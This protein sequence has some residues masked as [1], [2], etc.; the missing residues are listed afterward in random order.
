MTGLALTSWKL[1]QCLLLKL[2]VRKR[3]I[4]RRRS[5][6]AFGVRA[7]GYA[8]SVLLD[9]L[10]FLNVSRYLLIQRLKGSAAIWVRPV[11]SSHHLGLSLWSHRLGTKG[12]YLLKYLKKGCLRSSSEVEWPCFIPADDEPFQNLAFASHFRVK[13]Q[14]RMCI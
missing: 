4:V 6:P 7:V 13:R 9:S 5:Q 2:V 3:N 14:C 1:Q 12:R 8:A 10:S 11:G